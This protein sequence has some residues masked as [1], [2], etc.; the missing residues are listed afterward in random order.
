MNY[1]IQVNVGNP[2]TTNWKWLHS[3]DM[4]PFEFPTKDEAD[5]Q[6]ERWYPGHKAMCFR[7]EAMP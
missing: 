5:A 3:P 6:L 7:V 2:G 4:K 1:G